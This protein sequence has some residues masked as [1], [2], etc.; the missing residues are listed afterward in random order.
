MQSVYIV[1]VLQ[2]ETHHVRRIPN[3]A[4]YL[5][6]SSINRLVKLLL[7]Q[8]WGKIVTAGLSEN[9]GIRSLN[10]VSTYSSGLSDNSYS[11]G[12]PPARF[13]GRQNLDDGRGLETDRCTVYGL[14]IFSASTSIPS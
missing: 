12:S 4:R 3:Q 7:S 10:T 6:D 2:G 8:P 5:S 1:L 9:V 14:S 11:L 13:S